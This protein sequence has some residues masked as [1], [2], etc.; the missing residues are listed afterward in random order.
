MIQHPGASCDV[1]DTS[2]ASECAASGNQ[3]WTTTSNAWNSNHGPVN[4]P[5]GGV[6]A[7]LRKVAVDQKLPSSTRCLVV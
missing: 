2:I 5:C 6:L 1:L 7:D 4:L 3:T